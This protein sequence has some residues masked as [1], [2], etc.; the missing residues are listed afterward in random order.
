MLAFYK[1]SPYQGERGRVFTVY[2][3]LL[4]LNKPKDQR[5]RARGEVVGLVSCN[6]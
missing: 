3:C 4:V 5:G 6:K 2:Y 1:V